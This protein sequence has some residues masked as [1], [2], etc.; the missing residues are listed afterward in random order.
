MSRRHETLVFDT[1]LPDLL[2]I[3]CNR[4]LHLESNITTRSR[5]MGTPGRAFRRRLGVHCCNA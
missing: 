4:G 5:G 3:I 2:L 1:L